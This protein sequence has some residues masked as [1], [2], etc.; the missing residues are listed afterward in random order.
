MG[1]NEHD[2]SL[3]EL[4]MRAR[5][6]KFGAV[7]WRPRVDATFYEEH[8]EETLRRLREANEV[9]EEGRVPDG[10]SSR[11]AAPSSSGAPAASISGRPVTR[12]TS[13]AS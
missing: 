5:G 2:E 10:P 6:E 1:N 9:E 13:P 3:T 12:R 4:Y 8:P 7:R 11:V